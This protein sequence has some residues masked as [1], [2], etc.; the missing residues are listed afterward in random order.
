MT[1]LDSPLAKV[2]PEDDPQSSDIAIVGIGTPPKAGTALVAQRSTGMQKLDELMR[3]ANIFASAGMFKGLTSGD[4]KR[5]AALCAVKVIAGDELGLKPMASMRGIYVFDGQ[6]S[7]AAPLQVALVNWNPLYKFRYLEETTEKCVIEWSHRETVDDPWE[8]LGTSE[9]TAKEAQVAGL[10]G[11]DNWKTYF[12]RMLRWRAFTDGVNM[13][14]PEITEGSTQTPDAINPDV[15][16]DANGYVDAQWEASTSV[17]P[18][19]EFDADILE[20]AKRAGWTEAMLIAQTQRLGDKGRL[21]DLLSKT[22]DRMENSARGKARNGTKD[23][24]KDEQSLVAEDSGSITDA[25]RNRLF[26]ALGHRGIKEKADRLAWAKKHGLKTSKRA[27][28]PSAEPLFQNLSESDAKKGIDI[29]TVVV[30]NEVR[31]RVLLLR[32]EACAATQG[33]AHLRACPIDETDAP[34]SDDGQTRMV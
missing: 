14:C 33:Q 21:L 1:V 27:G 17:A 19:M 34:A 23:E 22:V 4:M 31:D 16:L 12:R 25:T 15:K 10:T 28:S 6:V 32:C 30:E 5:Q 7:L 2:N 26:G 9:F 18:A 11:K 29:L 3:Y 13:F 24:P 8:V 20:L